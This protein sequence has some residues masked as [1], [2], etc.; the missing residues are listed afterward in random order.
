MT[1]YE[2]RDILLTI[3]WLILW[4]IG[5]ILWWYA[6]HKVSSFHNSSK[7]KNKSLTDQEIG[8]IV[9]T[10]NGNDGTNIAVW[11]TNKKAL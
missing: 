4:I 1:L 9:Q 5:I 11:W 2:K 10:N 7:I 3:I 6:I 8:D